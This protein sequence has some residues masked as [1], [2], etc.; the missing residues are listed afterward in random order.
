[1]RDFISLYQLNQQISEVINTTFDDY[2]WVMAEIAEIRT[3]A[4]GHCY[5]ELIEKSPHSNAIVAR[6]RATIWNS[7]WLICKTAFEETTGQPIVAGIKILAMVKVQMHEAYGM[8]LNIVDID[9]SFTLGE[10]ALRRQEIIKRLKDEGV[11]DMNKELDIPLLPQRIAIISAMQ[12]AGYGDFC[13]Q[14]DNNEYGIR[15]YHHLFAASMQ[16]AN[17]EASIITALDSIYRHSDLFDLVVIIRGGGGVA[18]LSC[19]DSY[20]L[21][22]NVANFPL[23]VI[24]GIG[25]ERDNSIL[26][27]VAHTSVKTPT[28][29][30]AFITDLL[31][32]QY[33]H[34]DDLR[35]ATV[36]AI[37]WRM[38][39]S[40]NQ[41]A[42]C[43]SAI[44]STHIKL[45]DQINS[46]ALLSERTRLFARVSIDSQRQRLSHIGSTIDLC[47]PENILS[48][49]F[50]ITRIDGKAIKDT[51]NIPAGARIETTTA[52][53]L[54]VSYLPSSGMIS[55]QRK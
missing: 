13:H 34:I 17:T 9:A 3:A 30:A 24:V 1:M 55:P 51:T 46:L 12:A 45:R 10:M 2:Y 52:N 38:E 53:G 19:F 44:K 28:A 7:R 47:K 23:P 18:D 31:E 29:A 39:N 6:A 35:R 33:L 49:G 32:Q 43:L 21:A 5:L 8:S 14:L 26:D 41:I 25:H 16:G 50:S 27:I 4:N 42:R 20:D 36:E 37:D 15:F 40:S 22:V 48:R 11:I 54:L